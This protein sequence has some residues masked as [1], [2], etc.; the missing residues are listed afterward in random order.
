[1]DKTALVGP[2]IEEGRKFLALVT[3]AGVPLKAALWHWEESVDRWSLELVT[4]MV[5]TEGPKA[6]YRLLDNALRNAE[7]R[8]EIDLLNV[9]LLS[10]KWTFPKSLR[11]ELPKTRDLI[12]ARHRIGDDMVDKGYIYFVR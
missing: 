1:M 9:S 3:D 5:D 8:P 11:R 12:V 4:E 6:V 2:D 7:H 10:P